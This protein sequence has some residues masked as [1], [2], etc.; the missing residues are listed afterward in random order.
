MMHT[1]EQNGDVISL[2][3]ARKSDLENLLTDLHFLIEQNN[4]LNQLII[5]SRKS[6]QQFKDLLLLQLRKILF[7]E[8][9]YIYSR[10]R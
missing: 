6:F 9:C 7:K 4:I 3:K 2:L 1:S 8:G 5:L 10:I